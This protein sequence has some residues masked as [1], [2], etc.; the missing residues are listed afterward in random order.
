[1]IW[2]SL[3]DVLYVVFLMGWSTLWTCPTVLGPRL[4]STRRISNSPSV[5]RNVFLTF[6]RI[7]FDFELHLLR[8]TIIRKVSLSQRKSSLFYAVQNVNTSWYVA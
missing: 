2:S 7:L 5:G 6:M 1:M 8:R 3:S 4:Q